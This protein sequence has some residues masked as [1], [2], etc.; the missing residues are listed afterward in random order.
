MFLQKLTRIAR[1]VA[2]DHFGRSLGHDPS[3]AVPAFW[4]WMFLA[5][6]FLGLAVL[7]PIIEE[8]FL[9]G[10][11]MPFCVRSDWWNVPF[12]TVTRTAAV[13]AVVY[14]VLTHPAEMAAAAVW[15]A[16]MTWLMVKTKSLWD[17]VFAHAITNT[18]LGVYVV[19][20]GNW[21]MM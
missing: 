13:V 19:I 21:R 18:L 17:C 4:A 7:V 15:F 8:F 16:L 9:R 3:A 5:V 14:G 10:F 11:V 1:R 20:S 2:A 12:G 6:R